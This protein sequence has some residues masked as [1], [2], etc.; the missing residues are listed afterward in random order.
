MCG[1]ESVKANVMSRVLMRRKEAATDCLKSIYVEFTS[2]PSSDSLLKVFLF[3]IFILSSI[4]FLSYPEL[5]H[6]LSSHIIFEISVFFYGLR[7][8]CLY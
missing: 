7:T 6:R 2:Q 4:L 8:L 1:C 3:P 5:S